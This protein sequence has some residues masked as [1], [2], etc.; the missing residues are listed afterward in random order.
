VSV[1][2]VHLSV[3]IGVASLNRPGSVESSDQLLQ[4]ADA[5]AYRAKR[6]GGGRICLADDD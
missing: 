1:L 5:A 2:G 4:R 6:A 3:S